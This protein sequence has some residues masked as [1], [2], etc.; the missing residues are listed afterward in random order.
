MRYHSPMH[1][2]AVI[3]PIF[4]SVACGFGAGYGVFYG[5]LWLFGDFE[6][7]RVIIGPLAVF[8]GMAGTVIG[9]GLIAY[10]LKRD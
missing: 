8:C 6:T 1:L 9:P 7:V 2:L 3:F 5:G 4:A 10:A